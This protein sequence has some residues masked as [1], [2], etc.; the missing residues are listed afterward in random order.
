MRYTTRELSRRTWPDFEELFSRGNGWDFCA[1]MLSRRGRHLSGR[2]FPNRAAM[3]EQ[4]M[5]DALDLVQEGRAHGI[6]VY[7][8]GVVAGWCQYGTAEELPIWTTTPSR[9]AGE[10]QW[11]ITCFVTDKAYRGDGVARRALR[12]TLISI[13]K[14]GGGVV[15]ARPIVWDDGRMSS[16][17][18]ESEPAT[19]NA[20]FRARQRLGN[21]PNG[22][23]GSLSMFEAEGFEPVDAIL[24]G[25]RARRIGA[26]GQV[27][28]RR[29]V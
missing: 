24:P 17:F 22:N 23:K 18:P 7:A 6:L 11:R 19:S 20:W 14:K 21:V 25:T 29:K 28:V 8:D 26:P 27:I 1:C 12:A 5:A 2:S 3:R 4:N 16:L 9:A 10:R 13:R 15:E